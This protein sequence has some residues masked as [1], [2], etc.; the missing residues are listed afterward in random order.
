LTW[1]GFE[2]GRHKQPYSRPPRKTAGGQR[3]FG[4]ATL[5]DNCGSCCI[6]AGRSSSSDA[7]HLFYGPNAMLVPRF[8][9]R[10]L[11]ALLTLGAVTSVIIGTGFRGQTWAW[12][13]SI[14]ILSLFVTALVHAAWFAAIWG[15]TQRPSTRR[16]QQDRTE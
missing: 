15:T 6:W 11:L 14:G 13:I 12:G 8:S 16:Q 4:C 10:T 2:V 7:E 9:I 3:L 1:I 5:C